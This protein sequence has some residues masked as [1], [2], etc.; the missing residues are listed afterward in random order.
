MR[1][2]QILPNESP[3]RSRH[4]QEIRGPLSPL[5]R[6]RFWDFGR[7]PSANSARF[8]REDPEPRWLS[9]KQIPSAL[10]SKG[11]R[12]FDSFIGVGEAHRDSHFPTKG[13]VCDLNSTI[14]QSLRG[15]PNS[16][17]F[18]SKVAVSSEVLP[19]MLRFIVGERYSEPATLARVEPVHA[20]SDR[21]RRKPTRPRRPGREEADKGPRA[22]L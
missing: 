16:T 20:A 12:D 3:C 9:S 8:V 6:I 19:H 5:I 11:H 15:G 1:N 17:N 13:R 10:S 2:Y 14:P 18:L 22:P 21:V 7:R 4:G